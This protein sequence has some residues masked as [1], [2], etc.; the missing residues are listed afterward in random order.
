M[1]WFFLQVFNDL[2]WRNVPGVDNLE[3]VVK[4]LLKKFCWSNETEWRWSR[5]LIKVKE[6]NY[7]KNIRYSTRM[8]KVVASYKTL[9]LNKS[10]VI[11]G[12]KTR[13]PTHAL[14]RFEWSLGLILYQLSFAGFSYGAGHLYPW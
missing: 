7:F 10:Q 9:A 5:K 2:P 8:E 4:I 13:R 6:G 14:C 12:M 3:S 1:L 11:A